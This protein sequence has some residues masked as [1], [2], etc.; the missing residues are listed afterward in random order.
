MDKSAYLEYMEKFTTE[1]IINN[2]NNVPPHVI[3][4]EDKDNNVEDDAKLPWD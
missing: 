1:H 2:I 3:E 4:K